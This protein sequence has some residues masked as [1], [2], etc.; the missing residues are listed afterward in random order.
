MSPA[1]LA[2]A[3]L[4]VNS[5]VILRELLGSPDLSGAQAL[6]IYKAAKIIMIGK[7]E[8]FVLTPF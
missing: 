3:L 1:P 6:C 4:I 5:K 2:L 8:N 7:H